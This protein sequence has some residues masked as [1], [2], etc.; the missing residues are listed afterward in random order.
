MYD[1]SITEKQIREY[2]YGIWL[3]EGKPEGCAQQHWEQAT[4]ELSAPQE[5]IKVIVEHRY[6]GEVKDTTFS[7]LWY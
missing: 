5:T 3:R 4:I 2:A 1:M 7:S 6:P